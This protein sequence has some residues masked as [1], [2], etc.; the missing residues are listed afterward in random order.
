MNLRA[1]WARKGSFG[2]IEQPSHFA[3][4]FFLFPVV[5]T[6]DLAALDLGPIANVEKKRATKEKIG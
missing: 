1:G 4:F 5:R 6:Q 3:L 2:K